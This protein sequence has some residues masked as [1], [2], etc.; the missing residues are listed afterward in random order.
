MQHFLHDVSGSDNLLK[1]WSF[2]TQAKFLHFSGEMG[3]KCHLRWPGAEQLESMPL[4]S[5]LQVIA[6][7]ELEQTQAWAQAIPG[8]CWEY[9][10]LCVRARVCHVFVK[11]GSETWSSELAV[12]EGDLAY[13]I[14]TSG[15]TGERVACCSD[16][17]A[18]PRRK[19]EGC[20]RDSPLHRPPY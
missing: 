6:A 10:S 15:S 5:T 11:A 8:S 12:S 9:A 18:D 14:F 17:F 3:A 4:Q 16:C 2:P 13:V 1:R 20:C 19:A 7:D